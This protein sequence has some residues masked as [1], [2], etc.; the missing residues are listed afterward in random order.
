VDAKWIACAAL[1]ALAKDGAIQPSVVRKA[2]KDLGVNP[3]KPN[4]AIS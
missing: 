1:A 2:L 4:P 3:D